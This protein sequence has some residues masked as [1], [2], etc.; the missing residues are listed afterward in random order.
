MYKKICELLNSEK[1]ALITYDELWNILNTDENRLEVIGGN[2]TNRDM[3]IK[4]L[5]ELSNKDKIMIDE[6]GEAIYLL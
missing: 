1:R 4:V 6:R 5:K 2:I 3:M